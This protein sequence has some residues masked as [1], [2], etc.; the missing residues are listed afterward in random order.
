MICFKN[1]NYKLTT[2]ER[3]MNDKKI[4]ISEEDKLMKISLSNGHLHQLLKK[5][6]LFEKWTALTILTI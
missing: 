4:Y 3:K 5:I 1:A 2:G 6:N